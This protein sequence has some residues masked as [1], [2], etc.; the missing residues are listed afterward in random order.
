MKNKPKN[1]S[2]PYKFA[3][4]KIY[5]DT[6]ALPFADGGSLHDRDISGKL[7]NSTYASALGNMF[8]EGG[9]FGEDHG[10]ADY[11]TSIYASQP[12]N[13]YTNGGMIKRADGS[14]SQRGL[15]DN[16]RAAAGSNKKPTKQML[17]AE[18]KIKAAEKNLGGYLYETGG[19]FPR[20]Y[21]LPEDSFKQG[22]NNLHNSI[23]ASSMAQYPAT[24]KYGGSFEMP[25]QQMYMPLDNV[26]RYGGMQN[27]MYRKGGSV[28]YATNTPQLE[29]EGKDLTYP[30]NAYIYTAGGD[31]Q[32]NIFKQG[33]AMNFK[34]KGAYQNW[35]AYGHA[36]GEFAK[37]PGNQPVS[38][39]G[40]S[41]KVEHGMGGNLYAAGG[42]FNN[43]GFQSLPPAVQAKIRANA[44]Y[45]GY[46]Y[47]N[48]GQMGQL[49]EFN[50]GG[51]HEENPLGGI[52]QGTAPDGQINLVEQG[53]TKLDSANYIFSDTL[54]V[55]K[56]AVEQFG[57]NK[58]DIGKT[59]ADVS[60]K[61]NRPNSR[62]ENDTIEQVAIKRD[63]DS[64]MQ[65]QE[66][67]KQRDLEKD[68]AM[69][70]QKHPQAMEALMQQQSVQP[71][72]MPQGQ[73]VDASQLS[74]EVLQQMPE[75]Q[76]GAPVMAYGGG[77]YKCGGKM[78]N[79]GGHMY[80]GG[81]GMMGEGLL[82][83][84]T[85]LLSDSSGSGNFLTNLLNSDM[86]SGLG[87]ILES[88]ADTAG[89]GDVDAAAK[90]EKIKKGLGKTLGAGIIG[91]N[92]AATAA[93]ANKEPSPTANANSDTAAS[94]KGG[95]STIAGL[96]NPVAG[97]AIG[98]Q[99]NIGNKLRESSQDIDP[100]TGKLTNK[101]KAEQ[102][103]VLSHYV[104]PFGS[105]VEDWSNPNLNFGQKLAGSLGLSFLNKNAY[106]KGLEKQAVRNLNIR[107]EI[108]FKNR[109]TAAE[110]SAMYSGY[111]DSLNP[112]M[113]SN[114]YAQ[115][116]K[117]GG[118]QAQ[119][120]RHNYPAIYPTYPH[121]AGPMGMGL[122]TNLYPLGGAL[123]GD[124]VKTTTGA[125]VTVRPK[126]AIA[127]YQF[128]P[129]QMNTE[130]LTYEQ[131]YA[132]QL[133]EYNNNP[134]DRRGIP[135]HG[136]GEGG[137]NPMPEEVRLQEI[138]RLERLPKNQITPET[139]DLYNNLLANK[140]YVGE[141]LSKD[142]SLYNPET[143]LQAWIM[144]PTNLMKTNPLTQNTTPPIVQSPPKPTFEN[145]EKLA[146]KPIEQVATDEMS[147]EPIFNNAQGKRYNPKTNEWSTVWDLPT[148]SSLAQNTA[149]AEKTRLQNLAYQNEQRIAGG[150]PL[151]EDTSSHKYSPIEEHPYYK[152]G[153][154]LF[155]ER[156]TPIT[157]GEDVFGPLGTDSGTSTSGESAPAD[158]GGWGM[159]GLSFAN[160]G[161]IL[162]NGSTWPK[163]YV[164]IVTDQYTP[165]WAK[166][167]LDSG[168]FMTSLGYDIM[169]A[170]TEKNK[171]KTEEKYKSEIEK[172]KTEQTDK[173]IDLNVE[174]SLASGLAQ[175]GPVAYNLGMGLFG[176]PNYINPEDYMMKQSATPW[177]YNIQ[178]QIN[179]AR[180]TF[181]QG[182]QA[183]QNMSP[184]AGAYLSNLQNLANQR[185]KTFAELYG[186]KQNLDAA[187]YERAAATN[188]QIAEK[189][190]AT[191]LQGLEYNQGL[192]GNKQKLLQEG[193]KQMAQLGASKDQVDLQLRY[194]GAVSP[195]YAG[196]ASYTS[197][198]DK[199]FNKIRK[200]KKEADKN[201]QS[202]KS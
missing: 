63:L 104:D 18:K 37:T 129:S 90:M 195:D 23:Y 174:Q 130:G 87:S 164:S 38:I 76:Q 83:G 103:Y 59:F 184:G 115:Q 109:G 139:V 180:E 122:G 108:N 118:Y 57:L 70:M 77:M 34:S 187:A 186:Q 177:K 161:H 1:I 84:A 145:M 149:E 134:K 119:V 173:S 30:E 188:R 36:S 66:E 86:L 142:A 107:P 7:L 69:M 31:L 101:R 143:G 2:S 40:K 141:S 73:P 196:S 20:P 182:Q 39:Q 158:S 74:P 151:R 160:G 46:M 155:P 35:L 75:A 175:L 128:D 114:P 181:A 4:T 26:E 25:R 191:K 136:A 156:F 190:I 60:K 65:A 55:D 81:G 10:V 169:N 150:L 98:L 106:S 159:E 163:N 193:I 113:Q 153:Q 126:P 176:T 95:I 92:T 53:E 124:P 148:S 200:D 14:Y 202:K 131:W 168:E 11:A 166:P 68:M 197:L 93:Q 192:R 201:K 21:N 50:E 61:L 120:P 42:S 170:D 123:D 165:T 178:P 125:E 56:T 185:N 32:N 97:A 112:Q 45:G 100:K 54:K 154:T 132:K 127:T 17:Q 179:A 121:N 72:G 48:G 189:N 8:R 43:P 9:P 6:T 198:L 96:I 51:R 146:T 52:P 171:K 49:T 80:I 28:F 79:L 99:Q 82:G 140:V 5:R 22:G 172:Q 85:G 133:R 110:T 162:R 89:D 94:V 64:L 102:N 167:N 58:S 152:I 88:G 194:L 29:G 24:Y 116:A 137:W 138:A 19:Q 71:M 78:Y 33:G 16:I 13:Y 91:A 117:Y 105:V 183:L 144:P 67:F 157:E 47:D 147:M 12:G 135:S 199:M 62:R 111:E 44:Q 27:N 15:W 41:H 3:G